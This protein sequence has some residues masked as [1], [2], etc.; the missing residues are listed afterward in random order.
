MHDL[1]HID[2][3]DLFDMLSGHTAHYMK[4]LSDGVTKEEFN[5]CREII[6]D[7][8]TEIISR[9]NR[10]KKTDTSAKN[11]SFNSNHSRQSLQEK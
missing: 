3:S 1:T 6:T 8:Q 5:E 2:L 7:I 10:E 11:P 9:Q 4:M